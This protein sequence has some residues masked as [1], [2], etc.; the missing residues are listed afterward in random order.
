MKLND[1]GE[2]DINILLVVVSGVGW[3][4][5]DYIWSQCCYIL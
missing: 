3:L 1:D 2:S 5:Y 4:L